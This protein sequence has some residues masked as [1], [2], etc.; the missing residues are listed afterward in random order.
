MQHK[1][2]FNPIN[3]IICDKK[4]QIEFVELY[5]AIRKYTKNLLENN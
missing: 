4:S 3:E 5:T 1:F 2:K